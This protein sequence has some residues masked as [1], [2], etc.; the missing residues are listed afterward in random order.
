M[1]IHR[2]TDVALK[3]TSVRLGQQV[4]ERAFGSMEIHHADQGEVRQAG[5]VV[6]KVMEVKEDDR[7]KCRIAWNETIRAITPDH[8][9]LINRNGRSGSMA[10]PGQSL[11]I[12]ETDPAGYIVYAA[13]EAEKAANITLVNIRPFGAFGRMMLVGNEADIDEASKAAINAIIINEKYLF[14]NL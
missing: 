11:F 3:E 7:Q 12:L 14:K 8:A 4:V 10:L 5:E 1:A 2:Y 13:N 6:L 9:I